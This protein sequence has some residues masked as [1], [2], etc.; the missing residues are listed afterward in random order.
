MKTPVDL[1]YI[2]FD[3]FTKCE[4]YIKD[5]IINFNEINKNIIPPN[6]F[7]KTNDGT[8][9]IKFKECDKEYE[10]LFK[11]YHMENAILRPLCKNCNLTRSKHS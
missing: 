9:R 11:K 4:E 8:N 10:N 2:K 6:S 3:S 7:E 1:G 5:I